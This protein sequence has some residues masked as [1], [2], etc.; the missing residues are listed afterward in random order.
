MGRNRI[1]SFQGDTHDAA[2]P[3]GS[4]IVDQA[5]NLYGVSMAGGGDGC[6]GSSLSGCGTVYEIS[7]Q[8]GGGW[9]ETTLLAFQKDAVDGIEPGGALTLDAKGNL[10]GGAAGEPTVR[11]PTHPAELFLSFRR[12]RVDAGLKRC[13]T[14]SRTM[15]TRMAPLAR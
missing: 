3:N 14:I 7:P 4:L 2:F 15:A 11:A 12:G 9:V 10:Y 5:G 8:S 13:F 1:D 6:L